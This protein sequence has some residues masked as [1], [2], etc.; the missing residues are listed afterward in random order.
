LT[1]HHPQIRTSS[2]Y[3]TPLAA[4]SSDYSFKTW[5]YYGSPISSGS[6]TDGVFFSHSF[7][8][9]FTTSNVTSKNILR[10]PRF[11]LPRGLRCDRDPKHLPKTDTGQ[12]GKYYVKFGQCF[13][14]YQ[15]SGLDQPASCSKPHSKVMSSPL[16]CALF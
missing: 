7:W 8:N 16:I 10:W 11:W 1:L 9:I 12:R 2:C 13:S 6:A 14:R 5:K 3:R 4:R 15:C